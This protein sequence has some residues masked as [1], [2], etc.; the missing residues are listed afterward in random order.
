MSI[1][2]ECGDLSPLWDFGVKKSESGDKSPHSK[3]CSCGTVNRCC[4]AVSGPRHWSRPKVSRLSEEE[5]F[6]RQSARVR[7]PDHNEGIF[8]ECGDLSPLWD[9]GAKES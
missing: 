4:G 7:R 5:T 1:F 8:V 6:G 3:S 9:F 2:M